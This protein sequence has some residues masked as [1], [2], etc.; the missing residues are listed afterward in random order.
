MDYTFD[1]TFFTIAELAKTMKEI[2]TV[3]ELEVYSTAGIDN[4]YFMEPGNIFPESA[5]VSISFGESA[6]GR[7]IGLQRSPPWWRLFHPAP[8]SPHVVL[9]TMNSGS[10]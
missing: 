6:A 8:S 5:H 1:N 3:P 4:Y 10:P 7:P 2:G 9:G